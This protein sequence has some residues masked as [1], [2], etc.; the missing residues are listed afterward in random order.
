MREC[1]PCLNIECFGQFRLQMAD[2]PLCGFEK[3]HQQLLLA[4]LV[5]NAGQLVSRQQLAF[6][7]WPDSA[8]KQARTNLRKALHYLRHT[9]PNADSYVDINRHH[10][11][12]QRSRSYTLDVEAFQTAVASAE[13]AAPLEQQSHALKHAIDL[14]HGDLLPGHYEDW[15]LARREALQQT[16]L[17][18]LD[19]LI[20]LLE[21]QRDYAAAV[22]Y[23]RRLLRADSLH[24]AAYRRL[25]R[26]YAL[27]D[28]HAAAL[29][30][31]HTCAGVLR[32]ELDVPPSAA[33]RTL[34]QQLLARNNQAEDEPTHINRNAE[35]HIPL[36]GRNTAW[37]MLQKTW[38]RA[39]RQSPQCV[40]LRGEA[41]IGK[42][43]LAEELIAWAERQGIITLRANCYESTGRLSFAPI[44]TW[45]RAEV[46]ERPLQRLDDRWASEVSRI[47]PELATERPHLA[48]AGA[49]VEAWQRQHLF[50][51]LCHT[52]LRIRQPFLLFIDNLQW[53]DSDSLDWLAFLMRF[54]PKARFLLLGTTRPTS[55]VRDHPLTHFQQE[56][57]RDGRIVEIELIPL[58]MGDSTTLAGHVIGRLPTPTE[59][60]QLFA[61]AEGNPLFI[62]EM[63]RH[64][65]DRAVTPHHLT[66]THHYETAR[67]LPIRIKAV[68]EERLAQL[69]PPALELALLAA[70]IGR[71]FSTRLLT[72]ASGGSS[73]SL[74]YALDELW[75][76]R[77]IREQ[78]RDGYDFTHDK[79]REVAYQTVSP[80]KRQ[81]LHLRVIDAL[82]ALRE[83][84]WRVA[85]SELGKHYEIVGQTVDA[86]TCYERTAET[87][88]RIFA[89][90]EALAYLDRGLT[91][92]VPHDNSV[93][94]R[95]HEKRA[96]TLSVV[97]RYDEAH[98]AWKAALSKT[99]N[100]AD[101][102]RLLHQQG[103]TWMTQLQHPRAA[104][105]YK[106]AVQSLVDVTRDSDWWQTWIDLRLSQGSL[107][108]FQ[109]DL[110]GLATLIAELQE[111]V[112]LHGS[113]EQERRLLDMHRMLTF[114]QKRYRL[115][116]T[117]VASGH[118]ILELSKQDGTLP[119]I[120]AAYFSKGFSHLFAGEIVEGIAD[121]REALQRATTVGNVYLQ[122]Q[123]LAYLTL[124][125]RW[126][127]DAAQVEALIE[128]HR[129]IA[130][131]VDN[132]FYLGIVAGNEAWLA[133]RNGDFTT[134]TTKGTTALQ[135]WHGL[136]FPIQLIALWPLLAVALAQSASAEAVIYAKQL[137]DPIQRQLDPAINDALQSALSAWQQGDS[138]TT[139]H[140]LAN[141]VHLAQITYS[142]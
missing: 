129:P 112:A 74:L 64:G 3:P 83:A 69:S 68:V 86:L 108:Y 91:L 90:D 75:Q 67:P 35:P 80:S 73:S 93:Q 20:D 25:M 65:L 115:D 141:A 111:P 133:W 1:S 137:L 89:H 41:G 10:I 76:S 102:A 59:A 58:D 71:S 142:F 23:T 49:I 6:T 120:A 39:M 72:Q 106:E 36:I 17:D 103:N 46:M 42:T 119:H 123:C 113:A 95:L 63:A 122:D 45:L 125:Y 9:L 33:T 16:F 28:D 136:P 5:L 7:F 15:I 140:H 97:G 43:R 60:K 44:T 121:I 92:V 131:Q 61:E 24:E 118:R 114:R 127:D 27:T 4:Y 11:L 51:A 124:A 47:L 84:G 109:A 107:C 40:L 38:R 110:A 128:R 96:A 98:A 87:A 126:Q 134:A 57:L 130:E 138:A 50:S 26:L 2:E 117:D 116:A 132:S 8:E 18:C 12:W 30:V 29:R 101:R 21:A 81:L 77:I 139:Q 104:Q 105:C 56:M 19:R 52:L 62:V 54:A 34:Y 79:L 82:E 78:G 37:V 100:S 48:P 135:Q 66:P 99:S 53:C 32:R 85:D 13:S 55:H 70:T 22:R 14:Y 31:Y 88:R 94:R